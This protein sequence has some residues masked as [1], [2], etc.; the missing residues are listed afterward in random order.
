MHTLSLLGVAV[1]VLLTGC[2]SPIALHQAVLGYDETVSRLEREMLL[3]N[4]ARTDQNL[5][6]HFTVTSSIAATFDYRTN[7]G[8]AGTFFATPGVN[9]YGVNLGASAAENP[10]ISIV[11]VQGEEFTRRILTPMDENKF[12]FLVFQGAPIDMAM[13]LMADGIE[14]QSRD[15][16]FERFIL[17]WPTRAREY[18]EFRQRAMHVAWLNANRDL[19]VSTLAFEETIR[20]RLGAPPSPGDVMAA[21]EQGARWERVGDDGTWALR[22]PIVGR[23]AVTNYDPR[24]LSN[25]ERAALNA[26]AAVNP[27]NFVLVDIRP[28][29]PGGEYPLFGGLKLRSLNMILGFVAAGIRRAPEFDVEKDARTGEVRRNPRRTLA[30]EVGAGAPPADVPRVAYRGRSYAV[31]DTDWDKEAF[32][33]LYQLFQMTVTDVSKVG[34]PITIS[35]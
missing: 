32:T 12:E 11:P 25:S 31:G 27:S 4:I 7:V 6:P 10:T 18:T 22:R 16:T 30:I 23:V 3:V 20:T 26:V 29:H 5:P 28:G 24:A 21:I 2:V 33:I 19:F 9:A 34:V 35:K 15:G 8:F 17:N 1:A 13:R 14:V